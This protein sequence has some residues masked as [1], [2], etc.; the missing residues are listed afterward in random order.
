V[1]YIKV[2]AYDDEGILNGIGRHSQS[3]KEFSNNNAK[4]PQC[5]L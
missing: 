4:F 1:H 5:I 3:H 2:R